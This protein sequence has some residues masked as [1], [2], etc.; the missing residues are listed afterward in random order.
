VSIVDSDDPPE[1]ATVMKLA[2]TIR[3]TI[4]MGVVDSLMRRQRVFRG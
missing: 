4:Q 1:P 3:D 2:D